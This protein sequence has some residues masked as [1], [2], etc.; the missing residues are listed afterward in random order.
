MAQA[1]CNWRIL[2]HTHA[3]EEFSFNCKKDNLNFFGLSIFENQVGATSN[4]SS[5]L[6]PP[7]LRMRV[8]VS[9]CVCARTHQCVCVCEREYV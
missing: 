9:M 3:V 2:A 7:L 4:T 8:F 6:S 5:A 1:D